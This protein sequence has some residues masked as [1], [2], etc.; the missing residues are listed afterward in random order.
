GLTAGVALRRAN[1]EV[2]VAEITPQWSV[3][4]VGI[5]LTGNALRA[6]D[7]I[8]LAGKCVDVGHPINAFRFHDDQGNF[9]AETPQGKIADPK[10]PASC[11]ITRPRLHALLQDAV[12]ESGA[13]VRLGLSVAAIEQT[14]EKALVIFSD[15]T[16]AAYDLVIGADGYR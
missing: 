15:G 8:G 12:R 6:L 2:T 5:T 14:D 16:S 1:V 7:T 10:Y 4:G 13:A 9:L 3:T 11:G